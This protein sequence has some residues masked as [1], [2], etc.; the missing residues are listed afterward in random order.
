MGEQSESERKDQSEPLHRY[1]LAYSSI[2]SNPQ[3][4]SMVSRFS[5]N[6]LVKKIVSVKKTCFSV[7]K[8]ACSIGNPYF[9]TK[10][11]VRCALRSVQVV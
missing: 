1:V 6:P 10:G 3:K 5:Y 11:V 4:A 7:G 2:A 9:S 8:T